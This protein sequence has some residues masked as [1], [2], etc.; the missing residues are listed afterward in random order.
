MAGVVMRPGRTFRRLVAEPEWRGVLLFST[1]LAVVAGV[2]VM[3]TAVGQQALVDQ[4]ER[5][6]AA[7][8]H[9]LDDAGYRQLEAWSHYAA[10]YGAAGALFGVPV[11]AFGVAG[12]LHLAF[13]RVRRFTTVLAVTVHAGVILS[14]RQVL[15]AV[16]IYVGETTASVLSLGLAFPGL[17]AASPMARALGFI[18]LFVLWWVIL[19]A[20]GTAR[21]YGQRVRSTTLAF[22]GVYLALAV[23]T[24]VVFSA[25]GAAA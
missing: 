2:A 4:W 16:L 14:L 18:D 17:D 3:S 15:A 8:G 7:V 19:I 25:A 21:L 1:V 11:L 22:L 12:L 13:G 5:T 20:I 9:D 6:A 24:A 23:L 10:V